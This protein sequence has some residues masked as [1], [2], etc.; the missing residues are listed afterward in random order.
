MIVDDHPVVRK[1]LVTFLQ[2]YDFI[3]I[4]AEAATGKE[5]IE[6]YAHMLPDVVLMDLDMPDMDGLRATTILRERYPESRIIILTSY[7]KDEQIQSALKA[8]A[9]GY[10]L[11]DIPGEELARA[12]ETAV[13]GKPVLA[14]EVTQAL[15]QATT[16]EALP[17]KESLSAREQEVLALMAKGLNNTQIAETLYISVSTVK[18][19]VSNILWKLGAFTRTEAVSIAMMQ[20][21]VR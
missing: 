8:G 3:Q 1:G 17:A 4:V 12:V 5:A 20:G 18:F 16:R 14:P 9:I 13:S 2:T 15:I 10:L 6:K 7:K 21:L 19:H 11:K